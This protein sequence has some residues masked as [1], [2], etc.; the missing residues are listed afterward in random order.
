MKVPWELSR[1]QHLPVLAAGWV[2]SQDQRYLDEL[3]AELTSWI[4]SNPVEFGINWAC[5]MDVAVGAVNWVAALGLCAEAKVLQDGLVRRRPRQLASARPVH[6][7]PSG[8][9]ER[10]SRQ[11]L[12][13]QRGRAAGTFRR[14]CRLGRG[15]RLGASGRRAARARDEASGACRRRRPRG[16]DLLSPTC[17]GTFHCGCRRCR[18]N[19]AGIA[20]QSRAGGPDRE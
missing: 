20:E 19:S 10:R 9:R 2:V 12:S 14:V 4:A 18:R 11:S 16:I 5:T 17:H 3:G 6:P 1:C 15:A 8:V 7:K 13:G